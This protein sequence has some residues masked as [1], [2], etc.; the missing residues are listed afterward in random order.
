MPIEQKAYD[1]T[2]MGGVPYYDDFDQ[3]KKFLKMLFKPG[4]PVQ[5]RELTQAQTILQNQ[6]ERFGSYVFRN[7]SVVLGGGVST[8]SANFVRLSEELPLETLKRLVNQ[9]VRVTKGDGSNVDAIVCGYADK[10]SL[11]NDAFQIVFLKYTTVGEYESG[12]RVFTIGEGNIGVEFNVLS[13]STPGSGFV[14]TFVT[15]DQGVFFIDGYFCLA[16]AQ[17]AAATTDDTTLGYR[18]FLTTTSSVGFKADKTVVDPETDTSLRD[19]SFGFNNFNIT[20]ID[21]FKL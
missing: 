4:L 10:S 21:C 2:I 7:G 20:L 19:P 8:S 5:A 14:Q 6:I 16:D 18:T 1:S 17:S 9:K 11:A 12:E 3:Q 13:G 15:V